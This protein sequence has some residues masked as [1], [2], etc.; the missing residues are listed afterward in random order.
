MTS[1]LAKTLLTVQAL[2]ALAASAVVIYHVLV[3]LERSAGYSFPVPTIGASGV[4]LFFVISGFIMIYT[5][6]GSFSQP[7]ASVSFIRR[8][9]IRVVP[10]YWLYTSAIVILLAFVPGLFSTT[11]FDWRHVISSYLFLLSENSAGQAGTVLQTGWTLC[12]E[13][14]F[15][16]VFAMLLKLPRE[17]FLALSG[18]VFMTGITLGAESAPV[19]T[20]ATVATNPILL[21]FYI[22]AV[23]AFLF[24]KGFSLPRPIAAAS[25]IFGIATIVMTGDVDVGR[26]TRVICWGLPSGVVL[27]GAIS[28]ERAGMRVPQLFVALGDSSYSLYL[29]HPFIIAALGKVWGALQLSAM[30]PPAI[31]FLVVFF[32]SVAV[33]HALYLSIEKP[34][35]RWLSLTWKQR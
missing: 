4:D 31:P 14:Y 13:A 29:V 30:I 23:I 20:W 34:A 25:I 18:A 5:T 2:R 22:G 28:L 19:Q 9:V 21:D 16:V 33:S 27:L 1:A 8:R 24:L 15:Y 35:T 17:Y 32:C 11:K 6:Y 26:W 12:F 10:M 3:M 7:N